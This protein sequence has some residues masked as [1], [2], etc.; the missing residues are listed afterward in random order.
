MVKIN[1]KSVV[2]NF[3]KEVAK[4]NILINAIL[5]LNILTTL[6]SLIL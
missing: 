2:S 1:L 6:K 5:V 3:T 4:S